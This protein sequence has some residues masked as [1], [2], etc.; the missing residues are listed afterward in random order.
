MTTNGYKA[1]PKERTRELFAKPFNDLLSQ[2]HQALRDNFPHNK[3]Q[4]STLYNI[5][6]GGCPENCGYCSQSA[7]Y[8]TD[9]K[10]QPLDSL[11]NVISAAKAAKDGGASRFCMGAA[12]RSPRQPDLDV[13]KAM[14]KTVKGMGL[15]TCVTL[16]MVSEDQA[17]QLKE[18]GLDYYNHNIDTS[19]EFYRYVV[20]TRTFDDRLKTLDNVS[21]AGIKVCCGLI[22]GMGESSNDHMEALMTLANLPQPPESVPINMLIPMDGTPMANAAKVHPFDFVRVIAVARIMMPR[23]YV[24]LSAGRSAMSD[25]MHALCLFAG[26]NSIFFGDKLLTTENSSITRD[27]MLLQKLG[28]GIE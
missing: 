9:L 26:A 3:I 4:C 25:E 11:E 14:I 12:W 20:T 7:H 24:R 21:G 22:I 8:N 1:W 6:T 16:G 17:D 13:V 28:I 27:E 5:K 23:S 19:E 2:A 10:K 18:V 15:E